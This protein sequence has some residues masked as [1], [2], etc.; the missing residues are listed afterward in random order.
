MSISN[1]KVQASDN[2]ALKMTKAVFYHIQI[3]HLEMAR[4]V[5]CPYT[6]I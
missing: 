1:E 6:Q 3:N 5:F 2:V 4:L